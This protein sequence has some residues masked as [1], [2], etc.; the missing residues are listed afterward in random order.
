MRKRWASAKLLAEEC[1]DIPLCSVQTSWLCTQ[2]TPQLTVRINFFCL[3]SNIQH[4]LNQINCVFF[5]I[6]IA[7][8]ILKLRLIYYLRQQLVAFVVGH[9]VLYGFLRIIN[10]PISFE[11]VW[12]CALI[13]FLLSFH[14]FFGQVH[15]FYIIKLSKIP[16][17]ILLLTSIN[18]MHSC[19]NGAII[20]LL[21][22]IVVKWSIIF[23]GWVL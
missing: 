15:R 10:C 16:R 18:I 21:I 23:V 4:M 19:F 7:A 9:D 17:L 11:I 20:E 14:F 12:S 3:S 5:L 22:I 13:S 8:K 2:W 6:F 1:I